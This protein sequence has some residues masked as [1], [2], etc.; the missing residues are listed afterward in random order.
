MQPDVFSAAESGSDR[1]HAYVDS[2]CRG[3]DAYHFKL[4]TTNIQGV[5]DKAHGGR[6]TIFDEH[7]WCR[8]NT[9]DGLRDVQ[10]RLG[11]NWC[12]CNRECIQHDFALHE[13]RLPEKANH[14]SL[15]IAVVCELKGVVLLTQVCRRKSVSNKLI[16]AFVTR[17][18]TN[19]SQAICFFDDARA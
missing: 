6:L 17:A 15:D 16:R 4:L 9:L 11:D 8:H 5:S 12:K 1:G 13:V 10:E 14:S 19:S 18:G 3:S 2:R 7:V